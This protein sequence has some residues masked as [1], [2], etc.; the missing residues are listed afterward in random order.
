MS[1]NT[2]RYDKFKPERLEFKPFEECTTQ[3]GQKIT[4][5]RIKIQYRYEVTRAD[6]TIADAIGDLYI[7][8]PKENSKGPHK[9]STGF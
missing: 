3:G 4:Y 6:G 9:K 8:G 7:R 1:I 5:Y 2:V